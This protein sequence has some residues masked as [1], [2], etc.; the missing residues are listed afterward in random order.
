[1]RDVQ[2]GATRSTSSLR[3]S[4][5]RARSWRPGCPGSS[6][7]MPSPA[8]DTRSAHEQY[9]AT[10]KGPGTARPDD[11]KRPVV[12]RCGRP[13]GPHPPSPSAPSRRISPATSL[14][15][16]SRA[17]SRVSRPRA[18]LRRAALLA[19][20]VVTGTVVERHDIVI[21]A[22]LAEVAAAAIVGLLRGP[23]PA[24]VTVAAVVTAA[25]RALSGSCDL[26]SPASSWWARRWLDT[27]TNEPSKAAIIV[28]P[29]TERPCLIGRP[30]QGIDLLLLGVA[31][32]GAGADRPTGQTP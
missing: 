30:Q 9:R 18:E 6:R 3:T 29:G 19:A 24:S 14:R 28:R 2:A 25:L 4:V 22:R 26:L 23:L 12:L 15:C 17:S 5:F 11:L 21:D 27:P 8:S 13:T 1:M 16:C 32:C 10:D 7:K 20:L 31:A